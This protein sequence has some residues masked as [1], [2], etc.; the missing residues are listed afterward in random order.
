M[1]SPFTYK[2]NRSEYTVGPEVPVL[3]YVA[4]DCSLLKPGQ[5]QIS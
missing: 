4:G 5:A 3:A 2:D 1:N